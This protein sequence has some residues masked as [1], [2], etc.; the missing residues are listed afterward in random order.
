M[1]AAEYL[2]WEREQASKHEYHRGEVFLMAGG[3]PRHNYLA[4]AIGAE[5]R[6]SLRGKGCHVLSSD[7]RI[8]AEPGERYVYADAVVVCGSVEMEVGG[9]D[10]LANPSVV[11][12][13]LSK[14]TETYDRGVKWEAYQQRGSL[15][16]YVLVA[17]RS[18]RVEHFQREPDGTWRYRV[19]GPGDA[20]MLAN[21]ATV[22]IDV[23]YGDAFDL[24]A[25]ER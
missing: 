18:V 19:L 20:L 25:D 15:T 7:Q 8:A 23:V 5:L 22:A 1:S 16:D 11:V 21:G 6:A 14:G 24:P 17:Q 3:S 2:R 10:V 9:N 12:E 4:S 13:V